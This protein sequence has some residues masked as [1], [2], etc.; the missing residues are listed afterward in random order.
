MKKKFEYKQVP[1]GEEI[2]RAQLAF[3]ADK[4]LASEDQE[5]MDLYARMCMKVRKS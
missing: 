3:Y 4:I 5:D 2:C 1:V